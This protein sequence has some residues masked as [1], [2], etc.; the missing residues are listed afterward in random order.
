[1]VSEASSV[2]SESEVIVQD[3]V[4]AMSEIET[5]SKQVAQIIGVINEIAFPN[6]PAGAQCRRRGRACR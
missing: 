3:T 4:T 1:M 2:A 5:S 6:Q